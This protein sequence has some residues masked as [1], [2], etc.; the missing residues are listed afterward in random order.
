MN[1]ATSTL[2]RAENQKHQTGTGSI[3]MNDKPR[4]VAGRANLQAL[5]L[6]T[7]FA[8]DEFSCILKRRWGLPS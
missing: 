7:D 4:R 8:L 1:Q 6:A 3:I 5:Q 2:T